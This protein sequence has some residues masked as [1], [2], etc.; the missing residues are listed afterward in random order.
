MQH[1]DFIFSVY[2]EQWGFIG[3]VV[4]L[5]LFALLIIQ[6]V[7][8]ALNA[9]DLFGSLLVMGVVTLIGVQMFVNLGMTIG[10]VPI[11]GLPLPF[12]SYGGSSLLVFMVGTGLILNVGL[13]RHMF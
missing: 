7:T 9:R 8:I 3:V 1:T 12:V 2:A 10:L 4:L 11:T 5:F 13:R 6:G